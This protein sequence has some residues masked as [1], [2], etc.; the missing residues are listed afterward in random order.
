MKK[1][2]PNMGEVAKNAAKILTKA[3]GKG[4]G[5]G[6][7]VVG[8]GG[9]A[10]VGAGAL[11]GCESTPAVPTQTLEG[12]VV[13]NYQGKAPTGKPATFFVIDTDGNLETTAD[14][15]HLVIG[16]DR[17]DNYSGLKKEGATVRFRWDSY[18]E[19]YGM[20]FTGDIIMINGQIANQR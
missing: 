19:K 3:V 10:M 14:Q 16:N 5:T 13:R 2:S 1:I 18:D 6:L 9:A 12:P 17:V 11:V 7:K 15:K 4:L 20:A 8:A